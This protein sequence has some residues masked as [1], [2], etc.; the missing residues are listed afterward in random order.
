LE[1]LTEFRVLE[2][3]DDGTSLCEAQLQTGRTNQIR[4]HAWHLG[5]P[6]VG[7]PTYLPGRVIG[8]KQ[9]LDVGEPPMCLHAWKLAF[10][11]PLTRERVEFT[12]EPSWLLS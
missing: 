9:T 1:A 10:L 11:H 12:D 5:H 6:I 3:C 7:D 8:E 4:L 2:R